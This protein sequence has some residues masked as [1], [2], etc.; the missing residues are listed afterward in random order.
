M[1]GL[2]RRPV[3]SLLASLSLLLVVV[4]HGQEKSVTYDGRSLMINGKRDLFFSGSIHYP[5]FPP[6]MW[7]DV[8]KKAKAGGI[9]LIQTYVFWN[10]HEPVQGQ[11][12][13]NGSIDVVK[14]IRT[15]GELGL[16]VTLR[17]GPFIEAEWNFGGF[18]YWLRE[19]PDVAFRTDN[20]PFKHH[21]QKFSKMIIDMMKAEKLF[22]PQGGPIILAQI[23]NEYNNVQLAYKEAGLTRDPKYGHLRDLHIAL[24]LCQKAL[25]WGQA[26][27]EGLGKGLEMVAQHSSRNYK[28]SEI[29]HKSLQW[30]LS[31]ENI[32]TPDTCPIKASNPIEHWNVTK[33]A[34]DYLWYTTSIDVD[35]EDL[36]IRKN[37]LPALQ[38]ASLG[39]LMHVFVN[40]IY[41]GSGHGTYIEKSFVF[42]KP[43]PLNVGINH[44][45]ILSGTVGLPV[46]VDG[47]SKKIFTEEGTKKVKWTKIHGI[48][49]LSP[50][51]WYRAYFDMPEGKDPLALDMGT[52]AKGLIW[53]NGQCIGRYWVSYKTPLGRPSQAVYH[54]P[55][56]FLKPKDN[57]LVILEEIGGH[58]DGVK[59][60]TV[61]RDT[62]CSYITELHPPNV[63]T[64]KKKDSVLQTV[65]PGEP[66]AHGNIVCPE[67][68]K[69]VKVDFA[70]FGTPLG[71]C[72]NFDLGNCSSPNS[73]K[74][75]EE[76]CLGKNKCAVPFD[77]AAFGGDPCPSSSKVLAIQVE[78]GSSKK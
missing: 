52:M 59:V 46:G 50:L 74:T 6:E 37:M 61:N 18:P 41:I 29:A 69:I 66:K 33:D 43:V 10:L 30:E 5:R 7:P 73:V 49:N 39:H 14:Y 8:I 15:I 64:W 47:E 3:I 23:E 4:A 67:D 20:A 1:S 72:G 48:G 36:P 13:F 78:C 34:S 32:P 63:N 21:M 71:Y 62:I 12:N 42:Q 54:M 17:I 25:F 65:V 60:L 35:D 58:I 57:L 24:R 38:I 16:Y 27:V 68:K 45:Q 53:I 51:T 76:H 19:V 31:L 56:A 28:K 26:T 11:F 70:S 55:R 75:V 22:A 2:S 44:I 77:K 9:N 40:G